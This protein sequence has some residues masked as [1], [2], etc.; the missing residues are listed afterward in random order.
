MSW[1][2]ASS[3]LDLDLAFDPPFD[4][5]RLVDNH[6]N[7]VEAQTQQINSLHQ[8]THNKFQ[9][10]KNF[11]EVNI[12]DFNTL[13]PGGESVYSTGSSL[14]QG[15]STPS[16]TPRPPSRSPAQPNQRSDFCSDDFSTGGSLDP[17]MENSLLTN[18]TN[19]LNNFGAYDIDCTFDSP[20]PN[21]SEYNSNVSEFNTT[22]DSIVGDSSFG[23]NCSTPICPSPYVE[24]SFESTYIASPMSSFKEEKHNPEETFQS[25]S[26]E[27]EITVPN[28]PSRWTQEN[29]KNWIKWAKKELGI[30]QTVSYTS[31]PSN[32]HELINLSSEEIARRIG[33]KDGIELAKHLNCELNK[34]GKSLPTD[35]IKNLYR[36]QDSRGQMVDPY[37]IL[38]PV[39]ERLGYH[40][41]GQIQLW[42][43]L[44]ELLS[45]R[46]NENIIT[47][48]NVSGEFKILDP[49]AVAHRWGVRKSKPNMNYDK[50][51]RALRYYYDR[52][53]MTKV[54]GKRYAYKFDFRQLED[55][56]NTPKGGD[57]AKQ[58]SD[59]AIITAA[60]NATNMRNSPSHPSWS[61]ESE[62]M[63]KPW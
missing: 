21:I 25:V 15:Y 8:Q 35:D 2:F 39:C 47:W 59:M 1:N 57:S 4:P 32:G 51:S 19:T 43:Y 9:D 30:S 26:D 63:S 41:S 46:S 10:Q 37:E 31:L 34:W 7:D 6:I 52:N 11:L 54:P 17:L 29:I 18:A 14:S 36:N 49:D 62:S 5:Q 23:W 22:Y 61:Y 45:D 53:L 20:S 48:E 60:L 44:L 28:D 27:S 42:Q 55:L 38:R 24:P 12:V 3:L 50:L 40:G 16:S 33:F 13:S 58:H 56:H